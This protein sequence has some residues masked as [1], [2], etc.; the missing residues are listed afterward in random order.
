MAASFVRKLPDLFPTE[1]KRT[2][3]A[4]LVDGF[5]EVWRVFRPPA[6]QNA[7]VPAVPRSHRLHV[8]LSVAFLFVV[9]L[10]EGYKLHLAHAAWYPAGLAALRITLAALLAAACLL[11]SYGLIP[12][13]LYHRATWAWPLR[14]C[15][16]DPSIPSA[17]GWADPPAAAGHTCPT[18]EGQWQS[19]DPTTGI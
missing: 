14:P 16:A 10:V 6:G 2:G 17:A 11:F 19:T 12:A 18:A 7:A 4:L 5:K 13:G 9:F 3:G 1:G 15:P 8:L